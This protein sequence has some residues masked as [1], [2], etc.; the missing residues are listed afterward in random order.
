MASELNVKFYD[1][2]STALGGAIN[3]GS[4]IGTLVDTSITTASASQFNAT[5]TSD[6][7]GASANSL[8]RKIWLKNHEAVSLN[9][10][11][12]YFSMASWPSQVSMAREKSASDVTTGPNTIPTGY[13][14]GDF[15][16]PKTFA[17]RIALALDSSA[18]SSGSSRALWLR[19]K[20]QPGA[21]S[22][23]AAGFR[24]EFVATKAS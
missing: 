21:V 6:M 9:N 24:L 5:V 14:D 17:D 11:T 18:L 7:S 16:S 4:Q 12:V 8:Y 15:L 13:L 10:P 23:S 20:A 19:F 3:T 22:D 1:S 2:A